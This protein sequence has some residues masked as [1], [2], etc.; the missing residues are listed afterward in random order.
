MTHSLVQ[1]GS[2]AVQGDL[3]GA[4]AADW[5]AH[6]PQYRT[7]YEAAIARLGIG[8]GSRVLDVGCGSG[9]FLRAAVD[10]GAV[11]AGLDASAAMIEQALERVP[12]ADL[13]VG[14]LQFLPYEDGAFDAVTSFCSFWFAADP[15]AALREFERVTRPGGTVLLLV[16]GRPEQCGLGPAIG[17]VSALMPEPPRSKFDFHEPGV[18]EGMVSAAG[19]RPR[20]ADYLVNE[21]AWPDDAALIRELLAPGSIELAARTVGEDAVSAAILDAMQQFK[22]PDGGYRLQ[23]EWRY[24]IATA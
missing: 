20:E 1:Q 5:A 2:A 6:E 21:L 17:A 12:E 7:I 24:L 11:A 10:R 13:R 23:N 22:T 14:D 18:L 16:F 19:L 15:G 8:A 4:R 9:V 3:W